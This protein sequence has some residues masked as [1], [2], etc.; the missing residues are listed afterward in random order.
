MLAYAVMFSFFRE[1]K[2]LEREQRRE[3]KRLMRE[4]KL[5]QRLLRKQMKEREITEETEADIAVK[6]RQ[7]RAATARPER[8]WDHA[9]IPYEIEAN[10]SGKSATG[11][12]KHV[13]NLV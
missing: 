4:E 6:H 5:K 13:C 1:S 11:S 8:L 12:I 7:R 3:K 10:F 2:R 9:V